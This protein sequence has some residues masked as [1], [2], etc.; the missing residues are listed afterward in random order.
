MEKIKKQGIG[1][2]AEKEEPCRPNDML[3]V[4][5]FWDE[6]ASC[7]A[8]IIENESYQSA[9][10]TNLS[11]WIEQILMKFPQFETDSRSIES[12]KQCVI[13]ITFLEY[14]IQ[15]ELNGPV[16]PDDV[17]FLQ[18]RKKNAENPLEAEG[19]E[20]LI[21]NFCL[22]NFAA[23][24]DQTTRSQ[25]LIDDNAFSVIHNFHLGFVPLYIIRGELLGL[26]SFCRAL[27]RQIK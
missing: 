21:E 13:I 9:L 16:Y 26:A 24:A 25:L 7:C 4:D 23:V 19:I 3:E 20:D 11:S 1:D 8:R 12:L 10:S 6:R 18:K 14:L 27:A 5:G 17:P 2:L 15:H 22:G